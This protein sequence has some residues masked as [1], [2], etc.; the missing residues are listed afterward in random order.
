[1]VNLNKWGIYPNFG[2]KNAE[3]SLRKISKK[4]ARISIVPKNGKSILLYRN[5]EKPFSF[6]KK[7]FVHT[8]VGNYSI[9]TS[10]KRNV[11]ITQGFQII[12]EKF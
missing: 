11:L 3:I 1:M 5:V 7:K 6:K 2:V 4:K 9:G 12:V 10:K 8:I